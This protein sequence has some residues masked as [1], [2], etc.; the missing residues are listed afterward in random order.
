M[1]R[2]P[3][4]RNFA[5]GKKAVVNVLRGARVFQPVFRGLEPLFRNSNRSHASSAKEKPG[6]GIICGCENR[7]IAREGASGLPRLC[8]GRPRAASRRGLVVAESFLS[9]LF[10]LFA[11][12]WSRSWHPVELFCLS[13]RST[14]CFSSATGFSICIGSAMPCAPSFGSPERSLN[15]VRLKQADRSNRRGCFP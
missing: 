14:K 10:K 15:P 13:M 11:E 2:G 4:S 3:I 7:L 1:E 8:R 9:L 12:G 6:Y 5:S